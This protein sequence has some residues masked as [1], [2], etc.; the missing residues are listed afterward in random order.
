MPFVLIDILN[1]MGPDPVKNAE[2]K[3]WYDWVTAYSTNPAPTIPVPPRSGTVLVATSGQEECRET[4]ALCIQK[5]TAFG[6]QPIVISGVKRD[7]M[8]PKGW[9]IGCRAGFAWAASIMPQVKSYSEL[10][11]EVDFLAVA[12]DSVWPSSACT[13]GNVRRWHEA[14][15]ATDDLWCNALWL[16]TYRG[17]ITYHHELGGTRFSC[18]A[19]AGCKLFSGDKRFWDIA[20]QAFNKL[21][22]D[23]TSDAVFQLLAGAGL[24]KVPARFAAATLRHYSARLRKWANQSDCECN[25]RLRPL[26]MLAPMK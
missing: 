7:D 24:L 8:P 14:S 18:F 6:W 15:A 5:L 19:R 21:N 10:L 16:G 22:K 9:K 12:E 1:K 23:F 4:L 26:P 11:G 2:W 20:S 13:P 17:S 25:E 3:N